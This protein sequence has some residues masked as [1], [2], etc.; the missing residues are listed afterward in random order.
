[1]IEATRINIEMSEVDWAYASPSILRA[2]WNDGDCSMRNVDPGSLAPLANSSDPL[3]TADVEHDK[4]MIQRRL[5]NLDVLAGPF[6][7][8]TRSAAAKTSRR[9]HRGEA[10]SPAGW[11]YCCVH[12]SLSYVSH[13]T[14]PRHANKSLAAVFVAAMPVSLL[15]RLFLLCQPTLKIRPHFHGNKEW[16]VCGELVGGRG[17]V[18]SFEL[19]GP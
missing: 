16:G 5:K 7:N 1:M 2:G 4:V 6:S 8:A 19:Y 15:L 17:T 18:I 10:F 9:E 13:K 3:G 14:F 12:A 11:R